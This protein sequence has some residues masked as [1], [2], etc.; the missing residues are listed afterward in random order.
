MA[1]AKRLQKTGF[2]VMRV[3]SSS[4]AKGLHMH[5]ACQQWQM[6]SCICVHCRLDRL[7]SWKLSWTP[8]TMR[9]RASCAR[10]PAPTPCRCAAC[11]GAPCVWVLP[12][13]APAPII[14]LPC[15]VCM[16]ARIAAAVERASSPLACVA[17]NH[18]GACGGT[19]GLRR[20]EGRWAVR[21]ESPVHALRLPP[22]LR[23]L[24]QAGPAGALGSCACAYGFH[25]CT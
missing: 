2:C 10:C 22:L 16:H 18:A 12:R 11:S 19:A 20:V 24:L 4:G 7:P 8:R 14:T 21:Q 13:H 23:L 15:L 17:R 1:T 5:A 9:W 3:M 6:G 25:P